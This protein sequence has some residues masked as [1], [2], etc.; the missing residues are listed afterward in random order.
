MPRPRPA[1]HR[2]AAAGGL[3]QAGQQATNTWCT[4]QPRATPS[5]WRQPGQH[6][7]EGVGQ[8]D[9]ALA[10]A[11]HAQHG[12][13]VQ[14][15]GGKAARRQR[16]GHGRQQRRQQRHQ[17]QEFLGPVQRLAHLGAAAVQRLQ[18][19]AAQAAFHLGLGPVGEGLDGRALA[20]HGQPV[21]DAAG[22]LHQAGG[23][24]VGLAHHHARRKAH[25][26]GAAV[27][28]Q[29]QHARCAVGCR[30][31]AG[32]AQVQV[33]RFEHRGIHPHLAG[34]RHPRVG[35]PAPS[36]AADTSNWPRSG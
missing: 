26:A 15:V 8:R 24:Q 32:L 1:G 2:L 4:A 6:E 16:H 9:A 5:R 14:V 36:A 12:A 18:A 27:G 19:H 23:G 29:R 11:Q 10:Q 30:P 33:Q 35:S 25:E 21:G 20:R 7:L 34:R 31:A 17:V 22:R 3:D 13:V 28:L